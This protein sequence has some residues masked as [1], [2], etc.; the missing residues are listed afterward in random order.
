MPTTAS[1][2]EFRREIRRQK[3]EAR[4]AGKPHID[5]R[6][7]DLHKKIGGYPGPDHRM[8]VCCAAM[9]DEMEGTGDSILAQPPKGDGANLLIRYRV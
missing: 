8:P 4:N 6:S 3:A 9:R 2:E 1:K 5:I 7:G